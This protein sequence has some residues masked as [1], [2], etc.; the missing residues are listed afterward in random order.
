MSTPAPRFARLPRLLHGLMALMILAMLFIGIAMVGTVSVW[1]RTLMALHKPLGIAVLALALVRLFARWR[2][3]PPP[4]PA[5]LPQRQRV[6]ARGS[7][8]LLY[9]L[10]L[11][12][13]LIGWAM[14]S[15]SGDPV[16][17]GASI[18]LP[19]IVPVDPRLFAILR[20]AHS[21]L[22]L[23]LFGLVLIH[24]AA[25]LHHGLIRRD[26]VFS[27]MFPGRASPRRPRAGK[28]VE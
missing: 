18:R 27:T 1:H 19:A 28:P 11:A 25:A 22:A 7:H 10:M 17:L 26:G 8:G 4:L 13:P 24:L 14:L 16:M 15:A 6:A 21:A 5:E 23:L 12:L 2:H 9:G 3:A 20:Q